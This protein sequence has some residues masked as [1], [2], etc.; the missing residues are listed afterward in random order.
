MSSSKEPTVIKVPINDFKVSSLP[1]SVKSKWEPFGR[2][3]GQTEKRAHVLK[4]ATYR[5]YRAMEARHSPL[6]QRHIKVADARS[7]AAA[8]A[9]AALNASQSDSERSAVLAARML[10]NMQ[11]AEQRRLEVQQAQR[12]RLNAKS[13]LIMS[14]LAHCQAADKARRQ[15]LLHQ[16]LGRLAHAEQQRQVAC[17]QRGTGVAKRCSGSSRQRRSSSGSGLKRLV[18]VRG[19]EDW[20]QDLSPKT[21]ANAAL[22]RATSSTRRLQRTWRCFATTH[23]TTAQLARTFVAQGVTYISLD[24]AD[25]SSTNSN[26]SSAAALSQEQQQQTAAAPAPVLVM[27]GGLSGG[28]SARHA[29]FEDFADKLQAPA[30]LR[31]AQALLK[32]LDARLA[33]R[34]NTSD[35]AQALLR[36]LSPA[37]PKGRKLDRYPVRVM[38]C[39]YMIQAHPEVVFNKVGDVEARLSAAAEQLLASF[40]SL[41]ARLVQPLPSTAAAAPPASAPST[42]PGCSSPTAVPAA[43]SC[44]SPLTK[45]M[46]SY[47]KASSSAATTRSVSRQLFSSSSSGS[48]SMSTS[49]PG[50]PS[51]VAPDAAQAAAGPAAA[52]LASLLVAFDESWLEYLDQFVVWKGHDARGLEAELMRMAVRLERS[53]RLKLG[54]RE[55]DS[56]EVMANPDLK[57]M[58]V[59]VKHDHALLAERIARLTGAEGSARLAVALDHVRQQVAA[60]IAAA[61][62][63][64]EAEAAEAAETS[65]E[66]SSAAGSPARARSVSRSISRGTSLQDPLSD[67]QAL[68]AA[69]R[70]AAPQGNPAPDTQNQQ[71]AAA[72]QQQ[73]ESLSNE[74]MVWEMLYSGDSYALPAADA[75]ASW[76]RAMG[77]EVDAEQELDASDVESMTPQQLTAMVA[78]RARVIA[79]RAF[80]DSIVWRFKM[81]VQGH[82]LPAQVAPLLSEL[83]T[84]LSGFV[85]DS[86]EAQQLTEQCSEAA[87]LARLG[88]RTGQQGG[89]AN[90]TALGAMIEQLAGTL[91]RSGS[92]AR[93]AESAAATARLQE[94]LVA[95][96][97][98]AATGSGG[99][100]PPAE[101]GAAAAAALAEALAAALRLLMTQLKLV[102]LDAANARLAGLARAMRE[103]GAVGYL[104]TKLAAAWQLHSA[105]A[106]ADAE[107]GSSSA[108]TS[109]GAD[110]GSAALTHAAVAEKL[111]RTAGWVQAVQGEVLP[112]LQGGLTAAGLL[113]DPTAAAAAV[114]AGGLQSVELRSGVRASPTATSPGRAA[115]GS[116]SRAASG[117]APASGP[118]RPSYPVAL[119]SWQGMVRAGLLALVV[120]DTPAAGPAL[121]EVLAFDG[122]RLHEL[123][124]S[125]QQ[126]MVTA[127]GLL[128]VQQLRSAAGLAWD[129]EA[130]GQARRRLLVVLSD[131]GMKLSHLVTELSQLAGAGSVATEQRVKTMFTT[132][133]NPEA[134]AFKSIRSNISCALAAHLLYGRAAMAA[135]GSAAA[136]CS[137]LLARV[138]AAALAEDVAELAER[139]AGVAAVNEAVHG[140]LL[141]LLAGSSR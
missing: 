57:A 135:D 22:F 103:R 63:E 75:E 141:A 69:Q 91:L 89:G 44:P 136:N 83:G 23:K 5:V 34:G 130:R 45:S 19:L 55:P 31:A 11:A 77:Q 52:S 59:H 38:L 43:G 105:D 60:E 81:A 101:E 39:A 68:E 112:Q 6:K 27:I 125:L 106:A 36:Q 132:I 26:S 139:L 28:S 86:F 137:S 9:A 25:D 8:A 129:A 32:R 123:Q 111:H 110:A 104:Q 95:A 100:G 87:V 66:T 119:D 29:R 76:R 37:A 20:M 126:L 3:P 51:A 140:Q 73:P 41:L 49:R 84:E 92:E 128:I 61:E 30:T 24:A 93:A 71:Q 131:P 56:A 138:G 53:M 114:V 96:L 115:S 85:T 79:E 4:D 40:E 108:A 80:W 97:A 117:S 72:A 48:S 88:S 35:G 14:R 102:K 62:A 17:A 124:N 47:L 13:E 2:G 118:V 122:A 7:R 58:V 109:N 82:A 74:A 18:A 78:S 67:A 107:A 54:R 98:A 46:A 12:A 16:L 50:S 21:A 134:A 10:G 116:F 120:G 70:A 64:A 94:Q 65:S 127:A 15:Q 1:A 113:L 90:L 99:G 33:L 42:Q 133:V 121:P